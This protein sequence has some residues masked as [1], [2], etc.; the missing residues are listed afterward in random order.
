MG[1]NAIFVGVF[2]DVL[3]CVFKRFASLV[4][5]KRPSGLDEPLGLLRLRHLPPWLSLWR[6][7]LFFGHTS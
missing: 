7:L 1:R 3:Q 6:R 5:A 2:Q 4:G